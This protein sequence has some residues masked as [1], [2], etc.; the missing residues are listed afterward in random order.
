MDIV[1]YL[2]I[3][4]VWMGRN[5]SGCDCWGL[6]QIFYAKEFDI[7]VPDYKDLYSHFG[8]TGWTKD[9]Y[10]ALGFDIFKKASSNCATAITEKDL[11]YGD[12]IILTGVSCTH[13]GIYLDST[14][15]SMR[16]LHSHYP[17]GSHIVDVRREP[18]PSRILGYYRWNR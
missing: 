5:T 14:I 9:K 2:G 10:I 1:K 11:K 13:I 12:M 18:Y 6:V 4:Y 8:E 7:T 15:N 16:M 17:M 3:P